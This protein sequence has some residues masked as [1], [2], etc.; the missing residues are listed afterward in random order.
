MQQPMQQEER[1]DYLIQILQEQVGNMRFAPAKNLAEKKDIFRALMNV[2]QGKNL[3]DTYFTLQDEYLQEEL[4]YRPVQNVQDLPQLQKNCSVWQGDITLLA[5]DAIVNAANKTLLGCLVPLH[6]C[7]DTAI[8]SFAGLQ[9][10]I[11]CREIIAAQG[12][13]EETGQAKITPAYNLPCRYVIHTV[14]P[15]VGQRL[16][17]RDE[18]L[19]CSCYRS[20]LRQAAANKIK[21][22]AF[23]CIS[24]GVFHFPNQR[25]GELAVQ[26]VKAC[27]KEFAPDVHVIFN[28]FK[29][30]DLAV[31]TKLLQ[32]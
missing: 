27:Q 28:V 25:A 26:T 21:S 19:L 29:D 10:R 3:P 6:M 13:E 24:T 12:H 5:A 15:V 17:K 9:L 30:V 2:W 20:C 32:G 18:D 31:Y 23:C 1:L 22:L 16:T 8:H 11:K 14:G 4:K 7:I